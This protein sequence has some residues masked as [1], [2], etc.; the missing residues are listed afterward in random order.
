VLAFTAAT[1][2]MGCTT[3]AANVAAALGRNLRTALVEADVLGPSF[4]SALG[5]DPARNI[6]MV[7]HERPGDDASR[8]TQALASE[9]QPLDPWSPAAVALCG[10]PRP[11]FKAALGEPFLGTL[12][13]QLRLHS[14]FVLVDVPAGREEGT[15]SAALHAAVLDPPVPTGSWS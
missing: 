12:L 8:W 4:A 14:T 9:L 10:I 11:S 2:G 6:Y 13:E 15:P 3:V 5:L 7:A 1:D